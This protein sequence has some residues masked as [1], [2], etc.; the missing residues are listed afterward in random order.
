[1]LKSLIAG[2]AQFLSRGFNMSMI[3]KSI[4]MLDPRDE[5]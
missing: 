2:K 3:L 1:M 4:L 5:N